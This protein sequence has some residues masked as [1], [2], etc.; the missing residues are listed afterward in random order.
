MTPKLVL[1]F[2]L[3]FSFIDDIIPGSA[4]TRP[5]CPS[6]HLPACAAVLECQRG[7]G[8]SHPLTPL[9]PDKNQPHKMTLCTAHICKGKGL[10]TSYS[11]TYM[12]QTRDQQLY[13]L[14][15]GS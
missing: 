7:L 3:H 10:D 9:M 8:R 4:E 14:G 2:S 6:Q 12:N 1:R 15:T 11:A 5:P 13:N